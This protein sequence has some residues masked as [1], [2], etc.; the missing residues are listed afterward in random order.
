MSETGYEMMKRIYSEKLENS[1]KEL[2]RLADAHKDTSHFLSQ[3]A[4]K[5]GIK[6]A[7]ESIE[8]TEALMIKA[9]SELPYSNPKEADREHKNT[10]NLLGT[11]KYSLSKRYEGKA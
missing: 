7:I 8:G 5:L 6:F 4:Y 11:L 9:H 10:M 2:E 3:E 1:I